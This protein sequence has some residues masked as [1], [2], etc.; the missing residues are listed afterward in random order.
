M[1]NPAAVRLQ[2]CFTR[3]S[4]SDP[5]S[6]ARQRGA[7]ADEP[8]QEVLQL[9]EL[10]LKLAFPG[11]RPPRE[12]VED[13]LRAIDDLAAD[14]LLE[15]AQLRRAQLV[16]EDDDVGAELVTRR[17]QRL[18]LAAA[19]KCRGVGLRAVLQ[20][21][22]DDQRAGGRCEAGELVE[23]MFGIDLAGRAA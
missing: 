6:E 8:R 15:I 17:G 12:D 23:G 3:T 4:G 7:R 14:R 13:E 22:Q 10:D 5:A 11:L 2:L 19:E 20:N 18:H 1:A 21:A 16:V 9:R